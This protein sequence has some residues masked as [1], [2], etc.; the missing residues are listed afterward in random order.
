[1]SMSSVM[2]EIQ[3]ARNH[4]RGASGI[5]FGM[6][7]SADHFESVADELEDHLIQ[8]RL[9]VEAILQYESD[10]DYSDSIY[11]IGQAAVAYLHCL[12]GSLLEWTR[13]HGDN[14][15]V[16]LPAWLLDKFTW[17]NGGLLEVAPQ[18]WS[19]K[20][21]NTYWLAVAGLIHLLTLPA[22]KRDQLVEAA[23]KA[24]REAREADS[25]GHPHRRITV[26]ED[27]VTA[28]LA[29]MAKKVGIKAGSY[30]ARKGI[31]RRIKAAAKGNG[32]GGDGKGAA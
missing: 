11:S 14:R 20:H 24:G 21:M 1:M 25:A 31:V 29:Q 28:G 2:S 32:Q 19:G 8:V 10:G 30:R 7:P 17:N 3:A 15:T 6:V 5:G 27:D 18:F 16:I 26:T 13:E 4:R 12:E 9:L 22:E 23:I